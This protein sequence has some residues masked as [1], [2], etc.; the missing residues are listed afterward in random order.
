MEWRVVEVR[1]FVGKAD[2]VV[3]HLAVKAQEI[4]QSKSPLLES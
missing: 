4:G 2:M 3:V 1:V